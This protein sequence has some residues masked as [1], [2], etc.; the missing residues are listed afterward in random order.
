LFVLVQALMLEPKQITI[1]NKKTAS[2][3]NTKDNSV[4]FFLAF[5]HF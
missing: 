3:Y 1:K 4:H 2:K 5:L